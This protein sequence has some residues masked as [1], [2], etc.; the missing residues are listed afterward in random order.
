MSL[1]PGILQLKH[2]SSWDLGRNGMTCIVDGDGNKIWCNKQG[3]LHR[4]DGPAIIHADGS[5]EWYRN[6]KLHRTDGPAVI[7][8]DGTQFWYRNGKHHRTDGPA[9]VRADGYQSWWVNGQLHRTD[10]PAEIWGD[11]VQHWYVN[12]QNITREVVAWMKT[13]GP[14]IHQHKHYLH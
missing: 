2:G 8:S 5:R 4:T 10:G 6:D 1:S 11:G 14:G 13:P 12:N 9:V 7:W 3:Q